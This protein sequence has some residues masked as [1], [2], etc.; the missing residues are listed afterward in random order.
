MSKMYNRCVLGR[1][2][3]CVQRVG[4]AHGCAGRALSREVFVH[5]WMSMVHGGASAAGDG[6]E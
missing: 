5:I 4:M 2:S 6:T 1:D 3:Y